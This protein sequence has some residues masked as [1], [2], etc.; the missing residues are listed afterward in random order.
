MPCKLVTCHSV[1]GPLA[2]RRNVTDSNEVD[3]T[4]C[5]HGGAERFVQ[6]GKEIATRTGNKVVAWV[7][8]L[9]RNV[10]TPRRYG[11]AVLVVPNDSR[12]RQKGERELRAVELG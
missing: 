6:H 9:R 10:I 3:L 4:I 7:R 2:A 1:T 8:D 11:V 5:L 12:R